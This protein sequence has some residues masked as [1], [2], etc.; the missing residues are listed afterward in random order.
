MS[1]W[2]EG[3]ETPNDLVAWAVGLGGRK[4]ELAQQSQEHQ[5]QAVAGSSGETELCPRVTTTPGPTRMETW[6]EGRKVRQGKSTATTAS[7]VN[8]AWLLDQGKS[9]LGKDGRTVPVVIRPVASSS[10]L[11]L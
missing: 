8:L 3:R 4:S 11:Q 1:R 5:Q 10:R 9:S 2:G 6:T 7:A